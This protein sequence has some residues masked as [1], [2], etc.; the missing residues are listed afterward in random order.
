MILVAGGTGHLGPELVPLLAARGM[1]VR[2]M[3]RDPQHAREMLGDGPEIVN[4]DARDRRSLQS[5][6]DG[7]DTVISAITGFGPGG[8]GPRAVDL[9]GN[10]NLIHAAESAGVSRFIL[11]SMHRAAPD[12][13]MLLLRM[14]H[15][16]E[17]ALRAS[18]LE[19]TIVRPTV[20]MELW[21]GLIGDP[22]LK[23]GRTTLFGRG[24]NPVNF[25][26]VRDVARVVASALEEPGL[27]CQAIDAGGPEN[28]TFRQVVA[29]FEGGLHKRVSVRHVP[30]G[31]M[32]L[33][34]L[35][36]NPFR[37]DIA[38][39]I[40]AGLVTD[41]VDMTC[42]P[43]PLARMFPGLDLTRMADVVDARLKVPGAA[44]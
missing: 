8:P 28:L 4:G 29:I 31:V 32:R 11:L 13:P 26:S 7:A 27:S 16:A 1:P 37:P 30:I 21:A 15:A 25:V 19:W 6:L 9:E 42:D 33:A 38:G 18:S 34:R 3:T 36:L 2:V 35:M 39:M 43:A 14:K 20:F 41:T 5:A 10:V 24:D 17:E 23:A 44:C 22:I 12:H 40:E